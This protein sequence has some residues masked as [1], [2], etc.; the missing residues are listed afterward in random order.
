MAKDGTA[1]NQR[2]F[3]MLIN[4]SFKNKNVA[5]ALETFKDMQGSH[6]PDV[7][8]YNTFID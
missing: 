8:I 2:T 3:A 1:I 4:V 7:D 6:Q 5:L